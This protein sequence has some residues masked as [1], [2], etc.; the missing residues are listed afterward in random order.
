MLLSF[1]IMLWCCLIKEPSCS[2]FEETWN[3][4][5]NTSIASLQN[6]LNDVWGHRL[7]MTVFVRIYCYG[8]MWIWRYFAKDSTSVR[9]ILKVSFHLRKEN[10][11][12][13]NLSCNL[14]YH[15]NWNACVKDDSFF[16]RQVP[17]RIFSRFSQA[18]LWEKKKSIGI[19]EFP[20]ML[21]IVGNVCFLL[22]PVCS[23][24]L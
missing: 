18:F 21:G 6:I 20:D 16:F 14:N 13:Q 19:A 10:Y 2:V 15:Y 17:K 7:K 5:S 1:W 8:W 3:K 23:C 22:Y 12:C 9:L 24:L 11:Y 4:Q